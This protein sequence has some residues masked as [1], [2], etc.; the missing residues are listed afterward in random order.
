MDH[1]WLKN[2]R[3]RVILGVGRLSPDKNF[4]LLMRAFQSIAEQNANARL[5]LL[6]QGPQATDL[7]ELAR[8]LGIEDR[9]SMPGFVSNPYPFMANASVLALPSNNEGLP[10]VV[11]EA[12]ACGT[13]VVA[14]DCP[15]TKEAVEG[16]PG[17]TIV[18][19][20]D[21][22]GLADAILAYLIKAKKEVAADEVIRRFDAARVGELYGEL[23]SE[24]VGR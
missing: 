20:W 24:L 19:R 12:L 18:K 22:K 2:G 6:G 3:Y 21:W 13:P 15:G 17:A 8:L 5:I 14:T 9:V 16:V 4:G 7:K 1:A 11:I 23:V 10:L